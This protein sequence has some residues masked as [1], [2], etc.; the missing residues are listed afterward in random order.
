[1]QVRIASPEETQKL[2]Q[3]SVA[4]GNIPFLSG[5]AIIAVLEE[6]EKDEK[7]I[8]GFAAVQTALHAAGSWVEEKHRKQKHSYELR[9][10]L[11]GELKRR[12]FTVYFAL[13]ASDFEKAL[14]AKYG[15]VTEHLAQIRHL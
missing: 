2:S 13:P 7:N 10:C 1:M 5:Q 12:G 3:L 11:D 6:Q 15:A 8:I 14:F 4:H 9:H